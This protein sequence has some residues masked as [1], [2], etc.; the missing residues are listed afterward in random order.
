MLSRAIKNIRGFRQRLP[1]IA[2]EANLKAANELYVDLL[3]R[4]FEK[5]RATNGTAIG[6]YKKY[7]F[8]ASIDDFARRSSFNPNGGKSGKKTN[9]TFFTPDGWGGIRKANQRQTEFVDLDYTGSL[10]TALKLVNIGGVVRLV[11]VGADEIEKSYN[12][13]RQRQKDIFAPSMEEKQRYL[14]TFSGYIKN[15][16]DGLL[17]R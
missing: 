13:E 6:G 15:N 5:G 16:L 4:I 12:N 17:K 10:R 2:Q 9:K 3:I 1:Q 11:I 14:D 8:Y 7:D